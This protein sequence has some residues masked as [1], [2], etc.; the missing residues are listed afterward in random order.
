MMC[1]R[2][3]PRMEVS[4]GVRIVGLPV[5]ANAMCGR[6]QRVCVPLVAIAAFS[7]LACLVGCAARQIPSVNQGPIAAAASSLTGTWTGEVTYHRQEMMGDTKLAAADPVEP[8]TAAFDSRG[9]PTTVRV[10]LTLTPSVWADIPTDGLNDPADCKEVPVKGSGAGTVTVRLDSLVLTDAACR[11]SLFIE[12]KNPEYTS[13]G[14]VF[15]GP[16]TLT[17]VRQPDG[18]LSWQVETKLSVTLNNFTI[19]ENTVGSGTLSRQ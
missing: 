3:R 17:A 12:Y 19:S 15:S 2:L 16:H 10:H 9:K 5:R 4:G 11:M 14:A 18:T 7:T 6:P 13:L 1:P 8:T